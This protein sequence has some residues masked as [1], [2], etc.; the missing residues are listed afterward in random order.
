MKQGL[1]TSEQ[2]RNTEDPY[3][4]RLM[5]LLQDLVKEKGRRGAARVLGVD[6]RTVAASIEGGKLSRRVRGALEFALLTGADPETAKHRERIEALEKR[7]ASLEAAEKVGHTELRRALEDGIAGL[8]E[9]YAQAIR[10]IEE[11]LAV[12]E[13]RPASQITSKE[14]VDVAD[15]PAVWPSR[16]VYRELVTLESE[17]GEEQIYGEATPLIVEWRHVRSEFLADGGTMKKTQAE[18]RL[19]EL[20]IALIDEYGMTLPPATH[21]WDQFQKRD[22]LQ[23]RV[24]AMEESQSE[25]GRLQLMQWL[26]RVLTFGLWRTFV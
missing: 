3:E 5:S 19:R 17:P 24:K 21:P 23:R 8:R 12:L 22:E 2:S 4:L 13:S 10:Q 18:A 16:R 7:M 9:D 20:E 6:H 15:K 14:T 11:R 26:R 1:E 25:W